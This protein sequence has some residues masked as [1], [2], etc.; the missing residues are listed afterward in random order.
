V[1]FTPLTEAEF[2]AL[3]SIPDLTD[4]E[5]VDTTSLYECGADQ[6]LRDMY[7]GDTWKRALSHADYMNVEHYDNHLSFRV[8][9]YCQD[10][11]VV[12]RKIAEKKFGL[13]LSTPLAIL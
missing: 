10:F 13:D 7:G 12:E 3:M 1:T 2:S 4:V 5:G 8:V 11:Y 6:F 9:K